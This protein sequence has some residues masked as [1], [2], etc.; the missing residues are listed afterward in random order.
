MKTT[1]AEYKTDLGTLATA[2]ANRDVKNTRWF[3]GAML[4]I[5]GIAI[6]VVK[7]F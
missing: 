6:A 4:A 5:A 2:M 3:I 1:Q 7:L